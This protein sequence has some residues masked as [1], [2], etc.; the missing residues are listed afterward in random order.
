MPDVRRI[1]LSCSENDPE[2]N[3]I[4]LYFL[5][6]AFAVARYG[7]E[8]ERAASFNVRATCSRPPKQYH[9]SSIIT[10]ALLWSLGAYM[11]SR[12]PVL[13]RAKDVR[14]KA[15]DFLTAVSTAPACVTFRH[16]LP[17]IARF[18]R[19]LCACSPSSC[20]QTNGVLA[21]VSTTLYRLY[22]LYRLNAS[23]H[24]RAL[25]TSLTRHPCKHVHPIPH[26]ADRIED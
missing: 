8:A 14:D 4:C 26:A 20:L 3:S 1:Y 7:L 12:A 24:V 11:R 22:R 23:V 21:D 10:S 17:F 6:F 18:A 13:V 5:L 15:F 19:L 2:S 16:R 9:L 25:L